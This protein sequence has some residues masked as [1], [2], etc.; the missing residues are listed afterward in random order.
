[1]RGGS[2][3]ELERHFLLINYRTLFSDPIEHTIAWVMELP[4][5][6]YNFFFLKMKFYSLLARN[7]AQE[8]NLFNSHPRQEPALKDKAAS[9][10]LVYYWYET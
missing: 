4:T 10:V 9:R 6:W 8:I 2:N 3:F 1:M 5:R 7:A